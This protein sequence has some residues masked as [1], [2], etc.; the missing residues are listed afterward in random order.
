MIFDMPTSFPSLSLS[1]IPSLISLD[2]IRRQLAKLAVP[3]AQK[4]MMKLKNSCLGPLKD[5]EK[6]VKS[7]LT[8]SPTPIDVVTAAV[9]TVASP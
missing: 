9:Y 8:P 5:A 6:G 3:T 4:L 1:M 7:F 2:L